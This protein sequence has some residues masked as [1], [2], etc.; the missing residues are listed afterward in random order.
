MS[1]NE[2]GLVITYD[3]T[4]MIYDMYTD[5][6]MVCVFFPFEMVRYEVCDYHVIT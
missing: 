4:Y 1:V 5:F 2:K 3:V 6:K